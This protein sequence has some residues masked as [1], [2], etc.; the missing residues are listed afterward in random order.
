MLVKI[1][2]QNY[3]SPFVMNIPAHLFVCL[4]A[5]LYLILQCSILKSSRS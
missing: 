1:Q 2:D 5:F 4:S 3:K